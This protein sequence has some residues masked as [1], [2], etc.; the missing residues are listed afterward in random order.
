MPTRLADG[1]GL[2]VPYASRWFASVALARCRLAIRPVSR[3]GDVWFPRV[4]RRHAHAG[5]SNFGRRTCQHDLCYDTAVIP[6]KTRPIFPIERPPSE[7]LILG[8]GALTRCR[9]LDCV[10]FPWLHR[11]RC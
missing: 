10:L 2:E 1:L 7:S 9:Q 11:E 4:T 5:A 8:M 6:V 3:C